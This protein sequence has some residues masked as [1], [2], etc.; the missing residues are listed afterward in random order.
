MNWQ[1]FA[2]LIVLVYINAPPLI[3][4]P[5]WFLMLSLRKPLVSSFPF[6]SS[7]T[8]PGPDWNFKEKRKN[9][10]AAEIIAIFFNVAEMG[11][12]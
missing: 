1:F 11:Y 12:R 10:T 8:R 3:T 4:T 9:T 7:R 5:F 2:N 6:V